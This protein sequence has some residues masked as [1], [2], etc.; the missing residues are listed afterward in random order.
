MSARG[1]LL[2]FCR[3]SRTSGCIRLSSLAHRHSGTDDSI[4]RLR[5]FAEGAAGLA[6]RLSEMQSS[7]ALI[8]AVVTEITRGRRR[9]QERVARYCHWP[10]V[11]RGVLPD[12]H[13]PPYRGTLRIGR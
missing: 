8:V 2:S 10:Q 1:E 11:E 9:H 7:R 13:L 4:V 5:G 3:W 12:V 6:D